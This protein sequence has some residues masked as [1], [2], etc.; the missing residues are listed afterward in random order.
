MKLVIFILPGMKNYA[1]KLDSFHIL[2]EYSGNPQLK[3]SLRRSSFIKK[4]KKRF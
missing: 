3:T 1:L 2:I 4:M